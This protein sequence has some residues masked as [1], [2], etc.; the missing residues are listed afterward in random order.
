MTEFAANGM[1]L[2]NW[3]RS[4]LLKLTVTRIQI[5]RMRGLLGA[6][7]LLEQLPEL[8]AKAAGSPRA[9]QQ[10]R[11]I[12]AELEESLTA[13]LESARLGEKSSLKLDTLDS[14]LEG[15]AMRD[16]NGV[17]PSAKSQDF[18]RFIR[19]LGGYSADGRPA[20]HPLDFDEHHFNR[21]ADLISGDDAPA[22]EAERKAL[23]SWRTKYGESP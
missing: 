1:T 16:G 5:D 2:D 4:L 14:V 7:A 18:A 8:A 9:E 11:S 12:R 3:R 23:A 20:I 19:K 10:V 21:A 13:E 22:N 15:K 6:K 17:W